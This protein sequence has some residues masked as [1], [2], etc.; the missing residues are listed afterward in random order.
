MALGHAVLARETVAIGQLPV[1]VAGPWARKPPVINPSYFSPRAYSGLANVDHDQRWVSL[2]K[3]SRALSAGLI[4]GGRALPPDWARAI[5]VPPDPRLV[6]APGAAVAPAAQPIASPSTPAV[7]AAA[8][9]AHAAGSGLDAVRLAVRA[10]ES[11]VAQD[12]HVA[13]E[14]WPLYR[15]A[16]GYTDY[17]LNGTPRGARSHAASLAAAAAAARAAGQTRASNL[18]LD[19]ADRLNRSQPGYYGAAWVALARVM[20]TSNA[21]GACPGP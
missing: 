15:A 8:V 19:Q 3:T 13:A 17:A 16:P 4:G 20:L 21:L 5:A 2:T 11:C 18:L 1:L 10:A 9:G 7:V 12:R 14:L 6:V